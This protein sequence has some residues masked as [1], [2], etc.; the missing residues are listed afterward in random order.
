MTKIQATYRNF[1]LEESIVIC[2][3][4]R[5]LDASSVSFLLDSVTVGLPRALQ[6]PK[7]VLFPDHFLLV[8]RAKKTDKIL[9]PCLFPRA[10]VWE[11]SPGVFS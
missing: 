8:L 5:Q 9:L 7:S 2:P 11:Y 10:L 6:V 4:I 3:E 1:S